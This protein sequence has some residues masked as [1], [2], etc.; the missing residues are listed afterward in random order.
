MFLDL[1]FSDP[2][3]QYLLDLLT[4]LV[5]NSERKVTEGNSKLLLGG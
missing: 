2:F 1:I 4:H 5:G 3:L